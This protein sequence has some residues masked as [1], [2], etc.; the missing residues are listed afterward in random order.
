M[1]TILNHLG[2]SKTAM[3]VFTAVL[4]S[5][6]LQTSPIQ[7]AEEAP[8]GK[9]G[10][11]DLIDMA[12][13]PLHA[14]DRSD[15]T[16]HPVIAYYD[17][18]AAGS[19]VH[20]IPWDKISHLNIAFAGISPEGTCA[21]MDLSGNDKMAP[22]SKI[23]ATI[24]ALIAARDR[25]NPSTKLVLS[26]GGW[27][28]SYRF[29]TATSTPE[30]TQKLAQSCVAMMRQYGIDGLDYDWEYPTKVGAKNCPD[31]MQCQSGND[32]AQLT[33]LLAASRAAMGTD[34]YNHPLSVAV[35]AV[36]G[37]RGIPY[38][39]VG[40]DR[41]LTYWNI[42]AYDMAAPNWSPGTAFHAPMIDS[43]R[44]LAA[45]AALGATPIKLNLGVPYYSYVWNNVPSPGIDVPAPNN[46]SNARQYL[47]STLMKRYIQ[48]PGC[49]TYDDR[50][51]QYTYC[52][53][54][55]NQG[56]WSAVDSPEVLF[57]KASFVRQNNYGGV[58]IWAIQGDTQMGDLTATIYGALN[59]G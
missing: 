38:D 31:G 23:P 9:L 51:G 44:T 55:P 27:T 41:Y 13:S 34:A 22:N 46:K 37:N 5:L 14:L 6:S 25:H 19:S 12:A 7:A 59:P 26:V 45:F 30:G 28:M 33:A 42:M 54:G 1:S 35:Y 3:A 56:Q 57:Q 8:S 32:P 17:T 10:I 18:S 16:L 11:A 24:K 47:T 4:A 52:A 15:G 39:V 2:H 43:T 21:W 40:M 58:L 53:S 50:N 20:R 36:P 48:D 29:A 49:K